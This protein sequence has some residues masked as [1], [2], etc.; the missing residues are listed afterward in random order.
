MIDFSMFEK[1]LKITWV[2]RLCLEDNSHHLPTFYL[3]V[4]L[5]WREVINQIGWNNRF[6]KIDNVSVFFRTWS[7][8]GI[9]TLGRPGK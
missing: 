2:K 1:A 7:Q 8:N 3:K 4:I 5:Y 9:Q 6:I